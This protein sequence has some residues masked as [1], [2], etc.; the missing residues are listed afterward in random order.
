MAN[1][2]ETCATCNKQFLIIEPEQKFLT[3]KN[4]PFPKNCPTCR[5]TRRLQ[6]R[7]GDRQLYKT[8]CQKCGQNIV[9]AK[10]PAKVKNQIYCR[11]DYDQFFID[12][13]PI[14]TDPLPEA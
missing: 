13:D 7:G 3:G 5:Q 12:N 8:T 2:T 4:L 10:D 9:V 11:K 6:L 14:I 1:Q